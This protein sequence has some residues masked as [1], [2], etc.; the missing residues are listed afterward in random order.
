MRYLAGMDVREMASMG[1]MARAN[2]LTPKQRR[3]IATKASKAAAAARAKK[4]KQKKPKT[5]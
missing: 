2:S 3:D 1:G 5:P 4:A